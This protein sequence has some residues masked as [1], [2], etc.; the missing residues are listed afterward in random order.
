MAHSGTAGPLSGH[1][2]SHKSM[3]LGEMGLDAARLA[4]LPGVVWMRPNREAS[5]DAPATHGL[6]IELAR[7][8][9]LDRVAVG[10]RQPASLVFN[11][12]QSL[13]LESL[14]KQL[15]YQPAYVRTATQA[16]RSGNCF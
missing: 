8:E 14:E 5:F 2:G 7:D 1:T 6:E 13:R 16:A 10:Q 15:P 4:A 9:G 12:P 11:V 3:T